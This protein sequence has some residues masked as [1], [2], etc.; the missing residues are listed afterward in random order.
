[1][2]YGDLSFTGHPTI[3][4]FIYYSHVPEY[5]VEAFYRIDIEYAFDDL[6]RWT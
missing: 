4:I 2:E 6:W 3:Y 5:A 1:M